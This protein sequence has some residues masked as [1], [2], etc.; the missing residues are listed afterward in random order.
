MCGLVISVAISRS[1]IIFPFGYLLIIFSYI[2]Y[3][4]D[5]LT[6]HKTGM[7]IAFDYILLLNFSP[8]FIPWPYS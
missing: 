3:V 6:L 7:L 2:S 4:L 8:P 1:K 5:P